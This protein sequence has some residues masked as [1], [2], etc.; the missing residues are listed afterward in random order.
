MLGP[1]LR[2]KSPCS[3]AN[4]GGCPGGVGSWQTGKV[5]AV[6]QVENILHCTKESSCLTFSIRVRPSV[7]D[8][9]SFYLIYQLQ[10]QLYFIILCYLTFCYHISQISFLYPRCCCFVFQAH[11]PTFPLFP[12]PLNFRAWIC[13]SLSC[14][15]QSWNQAEPGLI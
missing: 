2:S 4:W 7:L 11:L 13:G 15:I 14:P 10:F 12:L 3:S 8:A 6:Q 5:L 1:T 9:L